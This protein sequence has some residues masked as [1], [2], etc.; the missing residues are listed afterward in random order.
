MQLAAEF[1]QDTLLHSYWLPMVHASIEL[2]EGH[3]TKAVELLSETRGY[4]L[5][6]PTPY[7]APLQVFYLRGYAYLA[8]GNNKEAASEFQ[9]ILDRRSLTVN[10]PSGPLS[11]LGL[12][13]A[14]GASGDTPKARTSYQDFLALWKD[15]DPDV[16]HPEAGQGGVREVLLTAGKRQGERARYLRFLPVILTCGNRYNDCRKDARYGQTA[17]PRLSFCGGR[18]WS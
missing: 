15:A 16:P 8:S 9:T 13:R 12:G 10:S 18:G 17:S 7:I 3:P 2:N 5:G 6:S 14:F 1:P 4:D 11:H